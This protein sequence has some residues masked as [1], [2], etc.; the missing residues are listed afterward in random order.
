MVHVQMRHHKKSM[1]EPSAS[2]KVLDRSAELATSILPVV[3]VA[4]YQLS[5]LGGRQQHGIELP[6]LHHGLQS[7]RLN[8][9][10]D[11]FGFLDHLYAPTA[12]SDRF[13]S[14]Q[15]QVHALDTSW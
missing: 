11:F 14:L 9:R 15:A 13:A 5:Q 6:V 1:F 4:F 7:I 3:F 2:L 12:Y 10:L 8:T